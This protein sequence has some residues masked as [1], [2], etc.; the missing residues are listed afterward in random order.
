MRVKRALVAVLS[1]GIL[2]TTG[3]SVADSISFRVSSKEGSRIL[4]III[5]EIG[6]LRCFANRAAFKE[7]ESVG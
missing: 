3:M 6:L 2:A 7:Q 4:F 5:P 1:S